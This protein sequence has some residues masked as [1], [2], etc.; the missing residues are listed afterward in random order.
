[1]SGIVTNNDRQDGQRARIV[2]HNFPAAATARVAGLDGPG[3]ESTNYHTEL[4]KTE[5]RT[6][7]LASALKYEFPEHSIVALTFT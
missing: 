3:P 5:T 7:T 4:V 1:L 2:L 6:V